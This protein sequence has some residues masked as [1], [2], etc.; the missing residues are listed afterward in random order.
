MAKKKV[1]KN[2]A[3]A[4]DKAKRTQ[5]KAEYSLE[6]LGDDNNWETVEDAKIANTGEAEKWIRENA[7][8]AGDY[9]VVAV[10]RRFKIRVQQKTEVSFDG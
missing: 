2:P 3:A 7:V 6:V 4:P 1:T 9:R 8:I 5:R 10:T